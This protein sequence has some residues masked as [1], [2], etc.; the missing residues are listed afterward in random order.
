MSDPTSTS[1]AVSSYCVLTRP[2]DSSSDAMSDAC[3]QCGD[4]A[5]AAVEQPSPS[6]QA[7]APAPAVDPSTFE[8]PSFADDGE[9]SPRVCIEFCDRC[10]WL[11]RATWTLTELALT[12]P[13]TASNE[14]G[15]GGGKGALKAITLVPRTEQSTA[16]RFR[17]WL[18]LKGHDHLVWDRKTE[19][20]FPEMKQLVRLLSLIHALT[21][22]DTRVQKQRI[23][24]LIAPAQDLGHSDSKKI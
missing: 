12:F 15:A 18:S 22:A 8:P 19:G 17:V 2:T 23:R 1:P 11:H 9:L 24:D 21:A 10:R 13:T 4:S 20:G 16:G 7:T 6:A 14:Q 3:V 5:A